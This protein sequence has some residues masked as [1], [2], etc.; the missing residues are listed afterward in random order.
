MGSPYFMKIVSCVLEN[1]RE[2][3]NVPPS[4]ASI[5][6]SSTESTSSLKLPDI[7]LLK[8]AHAKDSF[9]LARWQ[10]TGS[11]FAL[12]FPAVRSGSSPTR[13]CRVCLKNGKISETVSYY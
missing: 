5:E 11:Y 1:E 9:I 13:I 2:L 8:R 10:E 7:L 4:P 6:S 3:C 12:K